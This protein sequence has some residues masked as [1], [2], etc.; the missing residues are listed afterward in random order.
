MACNSTGPSFGNRKLKI[1]EFGVTHGS[2]LLNL[3]AICEKITAS[4]DMQF[5]I[6]GFD[7]DIGMPDLRGYKDHPEIWHQGQFK[8]DHD[9]TRK[10]FPPN[11]RLISGYIRNTIGDFCTTNLSAEAPVGFVSVDVDFYSSTLA[12]FKIFESPQTIT[13]LQP[14]SILMISMIYSPATND[15]ERY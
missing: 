11:A 1:L 8:S 14:F 10:Q 7:S 2:G 12:D 5:D 15:A 6:Y 13:Y 9:A 4:T 3:C